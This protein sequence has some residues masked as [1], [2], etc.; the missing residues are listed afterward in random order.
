MNLR[1]VEK[2]LTII[3]NLA[4]IIISRAKSRKKNPHPVTITP[5]WVVNRFLK[6]KGKCEYTGV[7]L[8]YKGKR[9]RKHHLISH[10]FRLTIDRINSYKGYHPN[11]CRLCIWEA[12][13]FKGVRSAKNFRRD[14]LKYTTIILNSMKNK[15][16]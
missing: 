13:K 14:Y 2:E 8:L 12:N 3:R 1:D 9:G 11:N 16:R 5:N 6:V 15:S 4:S 10:P 7:P